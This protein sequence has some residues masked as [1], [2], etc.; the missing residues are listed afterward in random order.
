[1][2]GAQKKAM[3]IRVIDGDT[4]DLFMNGKASR[5]RLAY[6]DAPEIKQQYGIEAAT[7]VTKLLLWKLVDFD[8]LGKDLYGRK[9]GSLLL[10]GRRVDSLIVRNGYAW[11][12]S[13]Y[14]KAPLLDKCMQ[15]AILEKKGLWVCGIDKVC[16]PW[17]YR[18]YDYRNRLT[19]CKGC[20]ETS[21]K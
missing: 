20:L 10:Y 7:K 6:I 8:S 19:Y 17:L 21:I 15:L 4:Y 14:G 5:V 2:L 9:V 16:P 11:Y 12:Y 18:N 1:M 13:A 3:V